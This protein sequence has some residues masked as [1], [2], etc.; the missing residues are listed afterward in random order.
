LVG[1]RGGGIEEQGGSGQKGHVGKFLSGK[2][3][4][5][6]EGQNEKESNGPR[7]AS[8][9]VGVKRGTKKKKGGGEER[10]NIT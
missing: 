9:T 6:G 10:K 7:K 3:E 1:L 8:G 4:P 5:P 2:M